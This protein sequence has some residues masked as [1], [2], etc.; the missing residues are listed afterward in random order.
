MRRS[1]GLCLLVVCVALGVG[2]S[3]AASPSGSACVQKWWPQPRQNSCGSGSAVDEDA[4][5]PANVARLAP[6]WTIE[7]GKYPGGPIVATAAQTGT[8]LVYVAA[9]GRLHAIDLTSGHS[10][11]NVKVGSSLGSLRPVASGDLLLYDNR[12]VLRR[13]VL[14]SGHLVWQRTTRSENASSLEPATIADGNWYRSVDWALSAYNARTGLLHWRFPLGCFHCGVAAAGGRVYVAGNADDPEAAGGGA[15]YAL[16]SYSGARIWT[17]RT[18]SD[19]TTGASPVLADGRLFVRTMGGRE[20]RREF[21]IEA[22]RASDGKH[23]WHAPVGTAKGFWFTPPAADS[24]LVVY[25][26]EDGNLYALDA[27][28]GTL[29]WKAPNI[30]NAIAPAIVNGVVWAGDSEG[31]FIAYDAKDGR[32]LWVSPLLSWDQQG[33]AIPSPVVAG[34]YLITWDQSG[35]LTAY[36]V[37]S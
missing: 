9:G 21:S 27:A 10:R 37:P 34:G 19:Y 16:D 5:S 29:R 14:R 36:H 7:L 6:V 18:A 12:I 31:H 30:E 20:L 28:T 8:P 33:L 17:R 4:P 1:L 11:W 26:S 24:A 3:R 35:R 23:L 22:Y 32:R 15:L 25:S 2:V 13:F